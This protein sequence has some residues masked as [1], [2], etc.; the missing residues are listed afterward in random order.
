MLVDGD[1]ALKRQFFSIFFLLA[2]VVACADSFHN[3]GSGLWLFRPTA[4][5]SPAAAGT[6]PSKAGT[7]RLAHVS[8]RSLA[9][10]T[11]KLSPLVFPRCVFVDLCPDSSQLQGEERRIFANRTQSHSQ[12]FFGSEHQDLEY[13]DWRVPGDARRALGIVSSLSSICKR[14]VTNKACCCLSAH[15][16][17]LS[18]T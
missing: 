10:R 8:P 14:K 1:Q 12:Q 13:R 11:S 15:E 9:T 4:S 2:C 16:T 3:T 18:K 6:G 7:H 5:L 17:N